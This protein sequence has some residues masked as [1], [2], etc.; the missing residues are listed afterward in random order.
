M[1]DRLIASLDSTTRLWL[2]VGGGLLL[3]VALAVK[4]SAEKYVRQSPR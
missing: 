1:I 2:L 4:K 3:L